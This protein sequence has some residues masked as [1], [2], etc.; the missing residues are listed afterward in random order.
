MN[1]KTEEKVE[2]KT[3]AQLRQEQ[4]EKINVV[5]SDNDPTKDDEDNN[6]KD[7]EKEEEKEDEEEKEEEL[8][9]EE[10]KDDDEEGDEKEEKEE[11]DPE[12][13]K[14]SIERMKR[15]IN[16][17]TNNEKELKKQLD[18][19]QA[20]LKEIEEKGENTLTEEDV[21]TRAEQKA[22]AKRIKDEFNAACARLE[23]S[24]S[25]TNK[26]FTD[27]IKELGEDYGSI[28]TYMIEML[29]DL[30]F[31]GEVLNYFIK[32]PE[33][34]EKVR[35]LRPGKMAT[36]LAEINEA[37]KPKKPVKEIS[38]VPP[39]NKPVKTAPTGEAA[40]L[41]ITG[42]ETQEEFN[43]KR[44]LQIERKRQMRGR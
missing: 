3:P 19:L 5:R 33:E 16:T 24:A 44:A 39:P 9:K 10:K 34:Y 13:L 31:G 25:A 8:E 40:N 29:D 11:D 2:E 42:K 36:K 1:Q 27:D 15:R 18:Q 35:T 4:R 22:E 38:K 37:V 28:P 12:K 41:T 43:R 6:D 17:K 21:E 30:K 32:N 14:R 7:D 23:E 20:K 26:T